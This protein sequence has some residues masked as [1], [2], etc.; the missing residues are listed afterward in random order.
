MGDLIK[1]INTTSVLN[2][3]WSLDCLGLVCGFEKIRILWSNLTINC[4]VGI[5]I[6]TN[7]NT[8]GSCATLIEIIL[9]II[10]PPIAVFFATGCSM[11]L[12]INILLTCLGYL[13]GIIHAM[14][15]I[16]SSN[17]PRRPSE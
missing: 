17:R 14:F 5:Y 10:F 2:L 15:V 9:A 4:W 7:N 12:L 1:E 13:P 11:D 3:Q 16:S 6:N 8:M